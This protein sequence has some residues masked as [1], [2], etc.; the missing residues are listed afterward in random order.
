M[1]P[2]QI[3]QGNREL[4][5]WIFPT[6]KNGNYHAVHCKCDADPQDDDMPCWEWSECCCE[7]ECTAESIDFLTSESA[8][9][10]VLE[11]MAQQFDIIERSS[12]VWLTVEFLYGEWRV[13]EMT[14]TLGDP[15]ENNLGIHL[16][17][18]TAIWLAALALIR[19]NEGR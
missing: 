5:D 11:K 2:E 15:G 17:R 18:K 9:A 7:M 10:M 14:S 6:F 4:Q 13:S 19:A 16:D 1:T 3:A 8:N 12:K